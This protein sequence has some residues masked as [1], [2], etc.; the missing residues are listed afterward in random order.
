M[1]VKLKG[2][3]K[4][5]KRCLMAAA[6]PSTMRAKAVRVFPES[7]AILLLSR[8]L[9]RRLRGRSISPLARFSWS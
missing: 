1:H 4:V 9:M 3:N 5:S 8:P 2:I 7:L 6:P